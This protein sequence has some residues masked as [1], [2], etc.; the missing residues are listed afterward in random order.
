MVKYSKLSPN[1]RNKMR[2]SGLTTSIQHC[3]GNMLAMTIKQEHAIQ[4]S[5]IG[6][7]DTLQMI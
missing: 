4:G 3:P 2:M 7:K 5:Y 6:K 1:I